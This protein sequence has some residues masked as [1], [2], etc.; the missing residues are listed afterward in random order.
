MKKINTLKY[1][2]K[3]IHYQLFKYGTLKKKVSI[4]FEKKIFR[5]QSFEYDILLFKIK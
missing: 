4:E 3:S 2:Q 1:I 5:K